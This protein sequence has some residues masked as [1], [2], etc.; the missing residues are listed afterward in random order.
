MIN[1]NGGIHSLLIIHKGIPSRPVVYQTIVQRRQYVILFSL[2]YNIHG[3]PIWQQIYI[4]TA[5]KSFAIIFS[6]G[7]SQ[8]SK[9]PS[10]TLTIYT[11]F[12]P[13]LIL[14]FYFVISFFPLQLVNNV[15]AC[16]KFQEWFPIGIFLFFN[17]HSCFGLSLFVVSPMIPWTTD[18]V[19][20]VIEIIIS[21]G[22]G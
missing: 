12:S 3:S 14:P 5:K 18:H 7:W 21:M 22:L 1:V 11:F 2:N 16:I 17:C 4:F 13:F 8:I 9:S 10:I 15:S 19:P 20:S 6:I